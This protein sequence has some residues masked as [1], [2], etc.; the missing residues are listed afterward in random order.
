VTD[1]TEL[2]FQPFKLVSVGSSKIKMKNRNLK[3]S[4][5]NLFAALF[6]AASLTF[7]GCE[8]TEGAG[9]DIQ[10]AGEAIEDAADDAQD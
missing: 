2:P 5:R 10:A 7:I 6:L 3:K 4:I 1:C 8:T 9:R